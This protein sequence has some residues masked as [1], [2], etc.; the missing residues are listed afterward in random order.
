ML[1]IIIAICLMT[2]DKPYNPYPKYVRGDD[3]RYQ[4]KTG[5]LYAWRARALQYIAEKVIQYVYCIFITLF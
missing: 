4:E 5:I 3:T 1:F 2:E